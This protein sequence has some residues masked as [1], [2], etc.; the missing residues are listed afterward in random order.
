MAGSQGRSSDRAAD[1]SEATGRIET[2]GGEP[3]LIIAKPLARTRGQSFWLD[4]YRQAAPANVSACGFTTCVRVVDGRT[5]DQPSGDDTPATVRGS[6]L[7]TTR[8]GK[9]NAAFQTCASDWCTIKRLPSRAPLLNF[10]GAP[11]R[12]FA[13][14]ALKR[15]SPSLSRKRLASSLSP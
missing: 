12:R 5:T 9:A 7:V 14:S 15:P 13:V 10:A 11:V 4:V 8:L 1:L 3:L 6:R 2:S